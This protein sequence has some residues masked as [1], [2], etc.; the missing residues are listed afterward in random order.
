MAPAICEPGGRGF[1]F[2][3]TEVEASW[4]VGLRTFLYLCAMIYIFLGVNIAA[5]KFVS[6]IE[7]ITSVKRRVLQRSTGRVITVS[8]WNGTVANL[9]LLALG[10]SAPEILLSV[11]EIMGNGFFAGELGPS[12]IVGSAAFNLFC[13]V[14]VCVL[15]VPAGEQRQIKDVGVFWVTAAFSIFAYLW[16]VVIV[17][18]NSPDIVEVWEAV[19][20]LAWLPLLITVSY[21]TDI[22]WFSG[23][24]RQPVIEKPVALAS[25]GKAPL[26]TQCEAGARN[27]PVWRHEL[28]RRGDYPELP[29]EGSETSGSLRS[30][31]TSLGFRDPGVIVNAHG[32]PYENDAG[33]ITFFDDSFNVSSGLEGR[34]TVAVPVFRKNG[35][36]GKISCKYRTEG[37]S[38]VAGYDFVDTQGELTWNPG[39]TGCQQVSLEILPKQLSEAADQFQLI[40][41]EPEGGAIFNPNHDGSEDQCVLTVTI[42]NAN[43]ELT[44]NIAS[45]Q[46]SQFV[47]KVI[48]IDKLRLGTQSWYEEIIS[49][50][51]DAAEEGE[52]PSCTDWILHFVSLPWKLF[53]AVLIP[54]PAYCGGWLCF[55]MSIGSIGALTCAICDFANLFGCVTGLQDSIT[56]ITIVALGT[57]VPDL[58]ASKIAAVSNRYADASIVNVT[59][60]NSVNVFLGIGLPW[61]IA[62][63]YWAVAGATDT[64]L[65]RYP[66]L[67][68]QWPNGAFVVEGGDLAF[69]VAV[70]NVAA[71]LALIVVHMRRSRL[72]AELGGPVGLKA[73]S[74]LFLISLWFFYV[75]L[76]VWKIL[77]KDVGIGQQVFVI[78]IGFCTL[79]NLVI[80]VS[81]VLLMK[82]GAAFFATRTEQPMDDEEAVRLCAAVGKGTEHLRSTGGGPSADFPPM[83]PLATFQTGKEDARR[84]YGQQPECYGRANKPTDI[85]FTSAAFVCFAAKRLRRAGRKVAERLR[86]VRPPVPPPPFTPP[87]SLAAPG[88]QRVPSFYSIDTAQGARGSEEEVAPTSLTG[89]VAGLISGHAADWAALTVAGLAAGTLAD[90]NGPRFL[91]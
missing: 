60:S 52:R 45:I 83:P 58:F 27:Q 46:M 48:N 53:L 14:G 66:H 2:P 42:H 8:V 49:S 54:P 17:Q 65:D 64:W 82:Y 16:L 55:V 30:D 11:V 80:L 74:G 12:T 43:D 35:A 63:I 41:E 86:G 69:S 79:E 22:G 84:I 44:R 71:A 89:R 32:I 91:S 47:D 88:V 59:G 29:D 87:D 40:L 24:R 68:G 51:C 56:A 78:F 31:E 18:V 76:S 72:G 28:R 25:D 36:S 38:A 77:A 15:A 20:T 81:C 75:I 3:L 5:D 39:E 90:P 6:A 26:A 50:C 7:G 67:Q 4:S 62:A 37:L 19:L 9:T 10:S 1:L 85:S 34:D 57:S 73:M 70:F 33:I 61:S 21:L 23:V 13:I